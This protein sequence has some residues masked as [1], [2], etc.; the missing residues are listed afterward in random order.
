M[1]R[2]I[3]KTRGEDCEKAKRF[4]DRANA[5]RDRAEHGANEDDD[6]DGDGNDWK[7]QA[8]LVADT[9]DPARGVSVR[10]DNV[11]SMFFKSGRTLRGRAK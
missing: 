7:K 8:L 9:L 10:A 5:L 11:A 6:G 4:R 1:C 2:V 3:Q